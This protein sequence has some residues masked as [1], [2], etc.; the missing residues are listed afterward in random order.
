MAH[1]D[2]VHH[3]RPTGNRRCLEA[4][5]LTGLLRAVKHNINSVFKTHRAP[6]N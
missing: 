5:L 3:Y 4:P 2:R 6:I 1:V